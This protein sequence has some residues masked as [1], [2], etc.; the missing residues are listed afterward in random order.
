[1]A[2]HTD[3]QLV[4]ALVHDANLLLVGSGETDIKRCRQLLTLAESILGGSATAAER[5]S[6]YELLHP[7]TVHH[8]LPD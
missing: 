3:T 8:Y 2:D 1:M 4:Y 7:S 5:S 6:V